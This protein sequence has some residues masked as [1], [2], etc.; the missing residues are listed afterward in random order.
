[1]RPMIQL[2]DVIIIEQQKEIMDASIRIFC[3]NAYL[4]TDLN[5]VRHSEQETHTTHHITINIYFSPTQSNKTRSAFQYT[6]STVHL[7]LTNPE[8]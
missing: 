2:C 8:P 5:A 7:P 3:C 4:M 6:L 1:M